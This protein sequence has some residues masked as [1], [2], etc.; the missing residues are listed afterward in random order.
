MQRFRIPKPG[1]TQ[2]RGRNIGTILVALALILVLVSLYGTQREETPVISLTELA[3]GVNAGEIE[4]ITVKEDTAI[5]LRRDGTKEEAIRE[6]EAALS[7]SL[8]NLGVE[9]EVLRDVEIVIERPSGFQFW[10]TAILP[11]LLPFLLL[12]GFMLF[13]IRSA[14]SANSRAMSFGQIRSKSSDDNRGRKRITFKDVAG[15]HEAKEELLEVVDFLKNPRRFTNIGAR[16]PKGVLLVGA[17]G[18]GKTLLAKAVAGEANVPFFHMSGSEFVEMFV[19]VGASRVRD[20]FKKAKQHAPAIV[21]VDELDAVGRHR[22]A[23]LGGGHDEREQTL[24]QILVE[25]DGFATD[26]GVVVISATNRPDVLDPALLRPGRFDRHVIIDVPDINEREEILKVHAKEKPVA[27]T[28]SLRRV[29]ERTPGFSGADLANLVNEAAILTVRRNRKTIGMSEFFDSIEKVLL[30]PERKSHILS[31]KEKEITAYHEAGH[32]LIAHIIPE[33]DPVRKVSIVSRG[34]AGGYTLKLGDQE[35]RMKSRKEFLG[36]LAT[37]LGGYAAEMIK[38]N[39]LTT[40]GGNDLR[41]A[42][43]LARKIVTEYGMS[44]LGPMTFGVKEEQ[45]FLGRDITEHRNYSDETAHRIDEE[46]NRL[47]HEA[48]EKAKKIIQEH[49]PKWEQVAQTLIKK[50]TLE[51]EDFMALMEDKLSKNS[52][53]Q[54][55]SKS[56]HVAR[57]LTPNPA[58]TG[59]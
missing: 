4:K 11:F 41:H 50:E 39:E 3:E 35:K 43:Q 9:T 38:F 34:R 42:T 49:S 56:D 28:V 2:F 1:G 59:G 20:L 58:P 13:M 22:G 45:I 23:G 55:D 52:D 10:A 33:V 8:R 53:N 46:V 40:G 47:L 51:Q 5:V 7:E 29:A 12:A 57:E 25:M 15:A 32:A 24:N 36:E 18:T 48:L 31:K 37:L 21:F 16:I 19:G 44:N 27:R 6:G 30:G 14:Q 17:P 54:E 26:E